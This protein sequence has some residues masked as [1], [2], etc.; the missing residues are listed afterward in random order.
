MVSNDLQVCVYVLIHGS[1]VDDNLFEI[2][3]T[4]ILQIY[5]AKKLLTKGKEIGEILYFFENLVIFLLSHFCL[6]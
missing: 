4:I 6:L 3:D 2:H 5:L 1:Q